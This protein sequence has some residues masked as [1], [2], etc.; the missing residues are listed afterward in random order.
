[1]GAFDAVDVAGYRS[2]AVKVV[3][4]VRVTVTFR[5]DTANGPGSELSARAVLCTVA[6]IAAHIAVRSVPRIVAVKASE[7]PHG[8]TGNGTI[9]VLGDKR[10]TGIGEVWANAH[11][12]R[13][14]NCADSSGDA[15]VLLRASWRFRRRLRCVPSLYKGEVFFDDPSRSRVT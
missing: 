5:C 10:V 7:A 9:R 4:L 8:E 3:P 6:N 14:G 15:R 11:L 13:N 1:M 12:L 2:C